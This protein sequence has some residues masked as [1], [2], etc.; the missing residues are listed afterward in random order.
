MY[1]PKHQYFIEEI[2]QLGLAGK[3]EVPANVIKNLSPDKLIE[4][5]KAFDTPNAKAVVTSF[6][7]IFSTAGINF[8]TGDF[9]NAI[10]L[11]LSNPSTNNPT[12]TQS[13]GAGII[14]SVKLPP[15]KADFDKGSVMRYFYKNKCNGKV[16]ELNK[17]KYINVIS[18]LNKC[19][20]VE[21]VEWFIKGP[22]KDQFINGYFVEGLET[23]NNRILKKL[24]ENIPTAELLIN[25]PLEYVEDT[26]PIDS[27]KTIMQQ[28]IKVDIP[29]PG[30]KL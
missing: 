4:L 21:K 24:E 30:K 10:K 27:T 17:T 26:H 6:G 8:S 15:T 5:T 3:L 18:T 1:I 29:S 9:T 16:K 2:Q 14:K 20:Q 19:E 22:A 11:I 28:E 12:I 25:S 7:E 13:S 23:K